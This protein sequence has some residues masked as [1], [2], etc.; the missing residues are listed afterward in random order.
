MRILTLDFESFF[1]K[2]YSL[3]KLSTEQYVRD[4]QF[5]AHMVGMKYP[6]HE[7]I[8]YEPHML[9]DNPGLR[10]DI[11]SSAVLCHH[12]HFDGLI[13]E[14]HYGLKP[15]LWLDTLSMARLVL[16]RLRSHSLDSLAAHFGLAAKSVPYDAFKGLRDLPPNVYYQLAAGCRHDVELTF[17]IAEKLLPLVPP[18]E[19]KIIDST[20]RMFVEPV[21]RLDRPRMEAFL[22][23]EK[24]RKAKAMLAAGDAMGMA[25]MPEMDSRILQHTWLHDRLARVETELQSSDKFRIALESIGVPCPMKHSE[26]QDKLIP[27][28]A[29]ND[30]G[31]KDLVEHDDH[32]VQ[33]LAAARLGVKSTIDET[34]AERLLEAESRGP[35]P[36]YLSYAAAKT[37]RFGGGD[38]CLVA[39]TQVTVFDYEKGLTQ[40]RIVDILADDLIWDGVEFVR[41]GGIVFSGYQETIEYEGI[42][43]TPEHVVYAEGGNEIALAEAHRLGTCLMDCPEPTSGDMERA[44]RRP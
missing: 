28:L 43:G 40:K 42:E 1:S 21:L 25:P 19:L 44:F 14:H 27:A 16:P 29:K 5:K 26:K 30:Q 22:K 10:V 37:L 13:L 6:G 34:R 7:P 31:M 24:I 20:I 36:V 41:H 4:P 2:D 8:V 18:S 15:A 12:A 39:E 23:A 35:L 11:E 32:R 3:S 17:Q 38:K 9:N 33:A